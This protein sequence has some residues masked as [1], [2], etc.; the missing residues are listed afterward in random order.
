[1]IPDL[2]RP[3]AA[4]PEGGTGRTLVVGSLATVL[5]APRLRR[6]LGRRAV[7]ALEAGRGPFLERLLILPEPVKRQLAGPPVVIDGAT[8]DLD[9]QLVL[10]LQRV[11]REPV[12]ELLPI[13]QG[14]VVLDRQA[15]MLA[16]DLPI[17]ERRDLRVAGLPA[18][19]YVPRRV[20]ERGMDDGGDGLLVFFHGGGFIYSG[21]DSHDAPCRLLAE[22]AD[23]RVLSIDYRLAPE[24]P[25]PAA[26]DDCV[27]AYRWVTEKA[28]WLGASTD[29]LAVGGDS[30]G[31]NLAAGVALEAARAGLPLAFQLL[32]YPATDMLALAESRERFGAGF[33]LTTE[34]MD[35][36]STSY[37]PDPQQR[38][39]PRVSPLYADV[40]ADLAPAYVCTAG[41]DPLRDEGEAYA[42]KLAEAGVAVEVRRFE[43]MIHG[44]INWVGRSRTAR[45]ALEEVAFALR[46]ALH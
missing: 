21:L 1:M 25:F 45:T 41:F 27:A 19:L 18:R 35:L 36:A 5:L 9:A 30:A 46:T 10:R 40:P 4:S 7:A 31:G 2:L 23:V 16:G 8:L 26:Y 3:R 42:A 28:G 22:Q 39:D 17:G 14:R 12:A 34:F 15:A 38:T 32:I 6:T 43:R 29:R 37:V 20:A 33:F 24:A 13:E 11:L 44:F